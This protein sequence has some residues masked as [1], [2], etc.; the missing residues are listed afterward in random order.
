MTMKIQNAMVSATVMILPSG[1]HYPENVERELAEKKNEVQHRQRQYQFCRHD[2]SP[3]RAP[4]SE[5]Q[6]RP[7]PAPVLDAVVDRPGEHDR[8]DDQQ[9]S[10]HPSM[11]SPDMTAAVLLHLLLVGNVFLVTHLRAPPLDRPCT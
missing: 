5:V 10:V 2:V 4:A 7:E 6:A 11:P 9:P 8:V 1:E 3:L